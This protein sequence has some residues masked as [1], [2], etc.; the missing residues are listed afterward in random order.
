MERHEVATRLERWAADALAGVA[1]PL[2]AEPSDAIFGVRWEKRTERSPDHHPASERRAPASSRRRYRLTV[3]V[4]RE[5]APGTAAEIGAL[6]RRAA[7]EDPT[8]GGRFDGGQVRVAE[9]A[10]SGPSAEPSASIDL[11]VDEQA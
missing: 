1:G 9:D 2:A 6:L 7:Q 4:S 8:L 5:A 10:V 3:T 11:T